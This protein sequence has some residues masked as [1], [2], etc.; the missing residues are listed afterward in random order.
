MEDGPEDFGTA[1]AVEQGGD[2]E[3]VVEEA[4]DVCPADCIHRCTRGELE[5]L[6]TYRGLYFGDLMA[7]WSGRRLVAGGEG[8][9]AS[10]APHWRDPLVHTSWM[11]GAKYVRTERAK[12]SDPLLH[13]SGDAT[14][15]SIIGTHKVNEDK[16]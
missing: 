13:H 16:E 12:L 3:D 4:I 1:R 7:K 5:V 9:G 6:E 14:E 8:G 10:A 2:P 11:K 15:F